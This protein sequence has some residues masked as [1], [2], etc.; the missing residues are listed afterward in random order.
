[1]HTRRLRSVNLDGEIRTR[2]PVRF[3]VRAGAIAVF[4]PAEDEPAAAGG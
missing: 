1:V 2:T 3:T 4:A